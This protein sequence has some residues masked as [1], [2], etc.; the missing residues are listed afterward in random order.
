MKIKNNTVF[1][2]HPLTTLLGTLV[3]MINRTVI[4]L[5]MWQ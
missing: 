1:H 5:I 2:I 3:Y 4:H